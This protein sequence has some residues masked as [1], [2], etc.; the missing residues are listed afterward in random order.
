MIIKQV[1][2]F[3]ESLYVGDIYGAKITLIPSFH[4]R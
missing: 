3:L 2:I 1:S 4:M